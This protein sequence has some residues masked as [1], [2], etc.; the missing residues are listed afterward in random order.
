MFFLVFR[1]ILVSI[2]CF[3]GSVC[4]FLLLDL[5][6][7]FKEWECFLLFMINIYLKVLKKVISVKLEIKWE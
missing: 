3:F 1:M 7:F 4:V 2:F 5:K 6:W